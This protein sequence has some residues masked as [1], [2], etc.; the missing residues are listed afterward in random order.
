[1][2]LTTESET[3]RRM[4]GPV[5]RSGDLALAAVDAI[6]DDNPGKDVIVKDHGAYIRIEAEG[7]V[8]LT[9]KSMEEWLGR[10]FSTKE[11]ENDLISF[12]GQIELT[13]ETVRWYFISDE[14]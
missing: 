1:M 7:G 4:A 10:Q 5:L 14:N 11:I 9:K 3:R 12:S 8:I 13:D 2:T 6:R